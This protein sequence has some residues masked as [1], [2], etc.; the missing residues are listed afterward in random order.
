MLVFASVVYAVANRLF[1]P[2]QPS[3]SFGAS[4][5]VTGVVVL[6]ALNFPKR[7][8][9]FMMVPSDAG[10]ARGRGDGRPGRLGRDGAS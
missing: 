2:N 5:A 6:Y 1:D 10:L 8:L 7:T 3:I 4:G 9:L